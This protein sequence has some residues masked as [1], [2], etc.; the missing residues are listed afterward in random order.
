MTY[1]WEKCTFALS[2]RDK[3]IEINAKESRIRLSDLLKKAEK[4]EEVLLFR[5]GKEVARLV[6]AK[7]AQKTL[8]S[9]RECRESIRIKGKPLSITVA[10]GREEERF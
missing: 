8:P 4:R 9:L 2:N 6:P 5:R 10:K 1:Q 3:A 7:K